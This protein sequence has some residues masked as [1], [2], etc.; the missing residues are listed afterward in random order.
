MVSGCGR[1]RDEDQG[2]KRE[3]A[4]GGWAEDARRPPATCFV[5]VVIPFGRWWQRRGGLQYFGNRER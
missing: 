4:R 5:L 1:R 3:V 2:K